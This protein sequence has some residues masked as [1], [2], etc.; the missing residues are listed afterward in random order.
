VPL[1][2]DPAPVEIDFPTLPSLERLRLCTYT[3]SLK[4]SDDH[5]VRRALIKIT[6][7]LKNLASI[8]HLT[9]IL[10]LRFGNEDITQVDWSPLADFLSDRRSTFQ[11]TDLYIRAVTAGGEVSSDKVV[12]MLS[13]YENLTSLVEAGYVSIKEEQY[14][15]VDVDRYFKYYTS[16]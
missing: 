5:L 3:S 8:K 7:I 16:S 1:M 14:R 13:R 2:Y 15:D 12:S 11:H 6:Q 10:C 9:L 4:D